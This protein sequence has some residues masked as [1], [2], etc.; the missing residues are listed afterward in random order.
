MLVS[1]AGVFLIETKN[2]SKNSLE[3]LNLR[4]PV[5]Q[6]Q[7]ASFA[8]FILLNRTAD[9]KLAPHHWGERKIPIKN[10]IVLITN[11]PREEFEYVKILTL[12][13]LLSYVE[14]FKPSM[15]NDET[16]EIADYLIKI[17]N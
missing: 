7:R 8:L 3:S 1:P 2:W 6:I 14:Y 13:K 11:K 4:S 5:Q 9:F 12:D 10:L 15:S 16:Q 17:R